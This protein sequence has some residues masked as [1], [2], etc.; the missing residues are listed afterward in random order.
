M[1]ILSAIWKPLFPLDGE[2]LAL[3]IILTLEEQLAY[4]LAGNVIALPGKL[5]VLDFVHPPVDL[6]LHLRR[7]FFARGGRFSRRH[8]QQMFHGQALCPGHHTGGGYHAAVKPV[9]LL[10]CTLRHKG[11]R[12]FS[13]YSSI[14]L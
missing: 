7:I 3:T 13:S 12:L 1:I 5:I 10:E 8:I 9:R 6:I 14:P 4:E 2:Y 11:L